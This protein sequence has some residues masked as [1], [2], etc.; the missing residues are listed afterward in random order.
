MKVIPHL[1]LLIGRLRAFE[2]T[3]RYREGL[4]SLSAV[5]SDVNA[6]PD[7]AGLDTVEKASLLLRCGVLAGF[8]GRLDNNPAAQENSKNLLTAARESFL[9]LDDEDGIVES[10]NWLSMAYMRKG[11]YREAEAWIDSSLE[12]DL[13]T[14]HSARIES[15]I[16]KSLLLLETERFEDALNFLRSIEPFVQ[17]FD[18]DYFNGCFSANLG[19]ILRNLGRL[20]D[21]MQ[22]YNLAKHFHQRS[23][24]TLYLATVENNLAI[25]YKQ[26]GRFAAAHECVD[27]A[28]DL[29]KDGRDYSRYGFCFDTKAS[30]YL[31]EGKLDEALTVVEKGLEVLRETEFTAYLVET[32]FTKIKIQAAKQDIAGAAISFS[33]A[34]EC[35]KEVQGMDQ[36]EMCAKDFE[37]IIKGSMSTGIGRIFTEKIVEGVEIELE[38]SPSLSSYREFDAVWIKNRTLSKIGLIEGYLAL[39]VD[40]AI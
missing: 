15:F 18:D 33:E 27:Y 22:M 8:L 24:N 10:E 16:C 12:R 29:Y 25:I 5:W 19:V 28:I 35:I 1:G 31:A 21:A 26:E 13:S 2:R 14:D 32:L 3:G 39:V 36:L 37:T 6:E 11:E 34:A 23:G 30:L 7:L 9:E 4:E 40:E 38:L 17:E 20:P